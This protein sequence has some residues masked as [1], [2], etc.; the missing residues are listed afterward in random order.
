M[1]DIQ[2]VYAAG[3][4]LLVGQ[5]RGLTDSEWASPSLCDGRSVRDVTAHLL[6]P[7]ELS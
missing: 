1:T 7:Y 6:M 5:L 4:D 2:S 3:R